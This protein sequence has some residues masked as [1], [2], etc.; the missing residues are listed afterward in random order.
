M[1]G[2]RLALGRL[3][4]LTRALSLSLSRRW[5]SQSPMMLLL[6]LVNAMVTFA[7][8]LALVAVALLRHLSKLPLLPP[9]P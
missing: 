2:V 1:S 5:L 6:T 9:L 3:V 7:L 8:L 4:A